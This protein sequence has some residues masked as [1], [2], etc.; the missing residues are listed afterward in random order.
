MKKIKEFR[1]E[2]ND[3]I[4]RTLIENSWDGILVVDSKAR[5]LY[6]SQSIVRMFGRDY[7]EFKG[8]NG[9][10]FVYPADAPRILKLFGKILFTPHEPI[11]TEMRIRHKSGHYLWIEAVAHNFLNDK[12]INGI[13]INLHD[14]T[15]SKTNVEKKDE[16]ISITT[17]E[18][19]SPIT[20]LKAYLQLLN[21]GKEHFTQ[22]K[23]DEILYKMT[24]QVD[25]L[26][27][28][29]TDLYDA[30]QIRE[31]KLPLRKE[32]FKLLPLLKETVEDIQRDNANHKVVFYPR[33]KGSVVADKLRIQQVITNLLSNAVK[34]SP[35]ADKIRIV[36]WKKKNNVYVSIT[37]YGIGIPKSQL[38]KIMNRFFQAE[39]KNSKTSGL[40]LGLYIASNII[41]Q[42]GG[43]LTVKSTVKKSTTITF[44]IPKK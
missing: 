43:I 38:T 11:Q 14:I 26:N 2:Q 8:I 23:I 41:K 37:D 30:S 9:I 42:H 12:N 22:Q 28:L 16:F 33:F 5:V 32:R 29:V 27:L 6:F 20:S 21:K 10:K 18:L 40:G 1:F 34:F 4:F 25:R 31:G 36:I 17:H 35:N 15:Q 39:T 19:R 44:Y 13:I 24:R 7:Q 3:K